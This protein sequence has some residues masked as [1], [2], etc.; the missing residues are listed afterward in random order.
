MLLPLFETQKFFWRMTK[1]VANKVE[2]V[3]LFWSCLVWDLQSQ[4]P[5]TNHTD[6]QNP[7]VPLSV[8][9]HIHLVCSLVQSSSALAPH[10][11]PACVPLWHPSQCRVIWIQLCWCGA[12]SRPQPVKS[13]LQCRKKVEYKQAS[14]NAMLLVICESDHKTM[15]DCGFLELVVLIV[16]EWT[17]KWSKLPIQTWSTMAHTHT[18]G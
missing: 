4:D 17:I 10:R 13:H 8:R 2:Q 7:L 5:N 14:K 9:S 11:F 1:L 12:V 16:Q 6:L 18:H 15:Q 3:G